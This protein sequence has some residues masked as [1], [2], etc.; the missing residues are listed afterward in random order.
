MQIKPFKDW[1]PGTWLRRLSLIWVIPS[2][3]LYLLAAIW[4]ATAIQIE[5]E[6]RR[7][8][9]EIT[10]HN[11]TMARALEKHVSRTIQGIDQS[12]RLLRFQYETGAGSL[13]LADYMDKGIIPREVFAQLAIIGA[14]GTVLAASRS[15][16]KPRNVRDREYFSVHLARDTRELFIGK[17][18]VGRGS[19]K[20]RIPFSRRINR[21]DGSFGGIVVASIDPFYFSEFYTDADIGM[22][23]VVGLVGRDGI[24]RARSS[25]KGIGSHVRDSPLLSLW[26]T[27]EHGHFENKGVVD[28]VTRIFSFHT[29]QNYPLAVVVGVGKDEAWVDYYHRRNIYL[30]GAS[31]S[32]VLVLVCGY[33]LM[34]LAIEQKRGR[35]RAESANK[36]KSEFLAHM[37]HELRTPLNGIL[38]GAEYLQHSLEDPMDRES[39]NIIYKSSQHLLNLVNTILDLARIEA[40]R[41]QIETRLEYVP[42]LI[43]DAVEVF[44]ASA[45]KKGLRLIVEVSI[46]PGSQGNYPVDRTKLVQIIN[47]LMDNAIKF[48]EQGRVRVS[49]IVE[50]RTL[51]LVVKDSGIGIAKDHRQHV[52]E[53]FRQAD[54]FLTRSHGGSG[55]G[56]ALVKELVRLMSGQ[57]S[58]ESAKGIGTTFYI[59][60]PLVEVDH[61]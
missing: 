56:L 2:F 47:N 4:L 17:P 39:A 42:G 53:R 11:E 23:G 59:I 21:P 60:I 19:G 9:Q 34:V 26:A 57:I 48:T 49:A 31:V 51:R 12:L 1:L 3:S 25:G 40:G 22:M 37:S 46:P 30:L 61:G 54:S 24:I 58:F 28:G 15:Q 43:H 44:R 7:T 33:V 55:L 29:V 13:T 50:A 10:R 52:F 18:V 6:Q 32:S 45:E 16:F 36:M 35:S 5:N 41:M 20:W 38:G 27:V 8:R 14:D